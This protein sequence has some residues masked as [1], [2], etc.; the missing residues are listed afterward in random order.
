LKITDMR[1]HVLGVPLEKPVMARIVTIPTAY[2]VVV[3][4]WTDEGH[5]GIG[6]G[7]VLRDIYGP[8]LAGLIDSMKPAVVGKD[9]TMPEQIWKAVEYLS[10]KAGPTGMA[11]WACSAIDVAVWDLFG[12]ITNQP[13]Y[14]LLGG[15]KN[16]VPSYAI[17]GLTHR[18][19]AELKD[20]LT[21]LT[22]MGFKNL[23]IFVMGLLGDGNMV[24][25]VKRMAELRDHVGPN[26][27]LGVDNQNSFKPHE[28]IKLGRMM[29]EFDLFWFEEPVNDY[30]DIAGM[31]EV[32][33]ALDTPVCSGEQ[34]FG[35][36]EFRPLIEQ[37]GADVVMVDVRMAGGITPFKKIGAMAQG[38]NR[39]VVSHMMTA[40]DAH[41]MASMTNSGLAEY[42]PWTDHIFE[43]PIK[44]KDGD[45]VLP[46]GPGLGVQLK[47]G[48]LEKFGV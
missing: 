36:Q 46:E 17:R 23:K 19:M 31:A 1:V 9:P 41:V 34:L 12:K 37:H 45:I 43:Q 13:L 8:P 33:A 27:R 16:T 28:A 25:A 38:W 3:Q 22:E 40:I 5:E 10:F 32:A 2:L 21:E 29:E 18:D 39:T 30:R 11:T 14:K 47:P 7:S 15:V 26:V 20:E 4:L 48:A 24:N 6:Y 42:V 44:L 35:I